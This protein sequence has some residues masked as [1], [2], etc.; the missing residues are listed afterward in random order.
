MGGSSGLDEPRTNKSR[1][2][3]CCQWFV[4]PC[5][6]WGGHLV[7]RLYACGGT[8]FREREGVRGERPRHPHILVFIYGNGAPSQKDDRDCIWG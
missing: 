2:L 5:L 8:W 4:V 7:G 6:L 1:R 3:F